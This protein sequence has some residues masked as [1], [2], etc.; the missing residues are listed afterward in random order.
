MWRDD[1]RN[2]Q[3]LDDMS[4]W[5]LLLSWTLPHAVFFV[6]TYVRNRNN[7]HVGILDRFLR[8]T[9]SSV[10]IESKIE[11]NDYGCFKVEHAT[12]SLCVSAGGRQGREG[13]HVHFF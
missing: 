7:G 11:P 10:V 1:E 12:G 5:I 8:P 3:F 4:S 13:L 6:D 2:A 9:W